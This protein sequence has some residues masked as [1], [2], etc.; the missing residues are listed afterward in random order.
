[1]QTYSDFL[2][3]DLEIYFERELTKTLLTH[4]KR[5]CDL[6]QLL[7]SQQLS[8]L[9]DDSQHRM[10]GKIQIQHGK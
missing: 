8:S 7:K 3:C 5:P 4:R 1:M 9:L 6:D 10:H 2:D